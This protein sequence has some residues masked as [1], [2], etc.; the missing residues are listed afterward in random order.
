MAGKSLPL[1]K[2]L[3]VDSQL[4]ALLVEV[5][6]F[7]SERFGGLRNVPVVA[8]QFAEYLL[9]LEGQYSFGEWADRV[10]GGPF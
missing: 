1:F 10:Q 5:A 9:A 3:Q 2:I 4:L 6:P 8:F 7:E